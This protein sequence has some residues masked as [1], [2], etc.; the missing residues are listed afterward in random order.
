M[1]QYT[2][3][4]ALNAILVA[5]VFTLVSV[6]NCYVWQFEVNSGTLGYFLL[7]VFKLIFALWSYSF[8]IE[9][10]FDRTM[11]RILRTLKYRDQKNN[12][13]PDQLRSD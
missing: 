9:C 11:W 6:L 13:H 3:C 4:L 7:P 2:R 8:V 10:A 5:F 1:S 12:S